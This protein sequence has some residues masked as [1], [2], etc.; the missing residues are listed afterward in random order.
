MSSILDNVKSLGESEPKTEQ[1]G[2]AYQK[3]LPLRETING[4][5]HAI[6]PMNGYKIRKSLLLELLCQANIVFDH[7]IKLSLLFMYT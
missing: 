7:L 5:L 6:S 4:D 2:T 3:S 1:R